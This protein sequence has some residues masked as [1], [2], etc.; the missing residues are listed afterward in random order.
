MGTPDFHFSLDLAFDFDFDSDSDCGLELA[1][2]M[3]ALLTLPSTLPGVP[4]R[5][6][7]ELM[8]FCSPTNPWTIPTADVE[9]L[10]TILSAGVTSI[11]LLRLPQ[12]PR[13]TLLRFAG[14][15]SSAA[16]SRACRRA[17]LRSAPLGST[18]V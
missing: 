1:E 3:Y 2:L 7:R 11:R 6:D 12:G 8:F 9:H 10:R 5:G 4:E 15:L 17:A 18:S 14:L 13:S 16:A